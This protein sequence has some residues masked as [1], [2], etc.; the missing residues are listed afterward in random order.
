MNVEEGTPA[1]KV[2]VKDLFAGKKGVLIAVPGAFTPSCND[3]S[4]SCIKSQ[5]FKLPK[6]IL[7]LVLGHIKFVYH[8]KRSEAS[9]YRGFFTELQV[10]L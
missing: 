3:V 10:S 7:I 6:S 1:T 2:D 4:N 9:I 5:A 8:P